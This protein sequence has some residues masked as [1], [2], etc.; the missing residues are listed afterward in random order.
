MAAHVAQCADCRTETARLRRFDLVIGSLQL[1]E[2]PPEAW[3]SFQHRFAQ[4]A[5]LGLGALL[6]LAGA[7]LLG[8][9]GL[10]LG[11][12]ALLGAAALPWWARAGFLAVAGGLL[13]LFG[14]TVRERLHTR[15]RT[16]YKDVVR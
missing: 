9:W 8:A 11:I 5:G 7:A 15:R 4:R 13:L 2:A 6:L 14:V 12:R 16:R 10:G 1:K 3:E